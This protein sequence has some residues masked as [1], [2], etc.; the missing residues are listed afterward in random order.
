MCVLLDVRICICVVSCWRCLDIWEFVF[1][2][3]GWLIVLVFLMILDKDVVNFLIIV[4][5]IKLYDF[6]KIVS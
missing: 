2:C 6:E 3:G 5:L 1:S 4:F